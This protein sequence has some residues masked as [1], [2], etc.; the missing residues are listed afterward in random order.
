M[1]LIVNRNELKAA[2][3]FICNDETRPEICGVHVEVK[4]NAQPIMVATDGKRLAV[5]ET[6]ALQEDGGVPLL[7]NEAHSFI[8][9]RE[10]VGLVIALSKT[11]GGKTFPLV[12]IEQKQG[13]KRISASV[14]GPCGFL[15]IE[16]GGLIEGDYP[17]WRQVLPAKT[18]ERN[19][20]SEIGISSQFISDY[21]KAGK[22]LDAKSLALSLN[23]ISKD[24]AIEVKIGELR[25][26]YSVIMPCKLQ[27]EIDFQPAYLNGFEPTA[28]AA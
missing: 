8:L 28:K 20:V 3:L 10:F 24:A 4:P 13:S 22:A 6:D 1:K 16:N 26:F 23:L 2:L 12:A 14:I 11:R 7:F 25:K 27:D 17:K 18:A 15:E 21:A 9:N 19:P 5:I